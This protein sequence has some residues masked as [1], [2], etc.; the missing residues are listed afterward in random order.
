MRAEW[1]QVVAS[2]AIVEKIRVAGFEP[3]PGDSIEK[4]STT[5]HED[6]V[7][8]GRIIKETGIRLD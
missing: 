1:R 5:I 7:R 8:Y 2:P 4:F 3:V 6:Y